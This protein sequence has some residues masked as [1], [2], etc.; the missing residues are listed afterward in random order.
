MTGF[1]DFQGFLVSRALVPSRVS[2]AYCSNR[3]EHFGLGLQ[4]GIGCGHGLRAAALCPAIPSLA[5]AG[6]CA[7]CRVGFPHRCRRRSLCSPIGSGVPPTSGACRQ[8]NRRA[9]PERIFGSLRNRSPARSIGT[10]VLFIGI[11][12][13]P[14]LQREEPH[15][16]DF[17]CFGRT[18]PS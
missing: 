7:G 13:R 8:H 15:C 1:Q 5:V 3:A 9:S 14:Q 4:R 10:A 17:L 18:R 6:R 2:P 12:E 16:V 11:S